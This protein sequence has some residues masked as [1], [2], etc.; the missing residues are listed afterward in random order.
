M[1]EQVTQDLNTA[2]AGRDREL[3]RLGQ[4]GLTP[5]DIIKLLPFIEKVTRLQDELDRASENLRSCVNEYPYLC[6]AHGPR[7]SDS[8]VEL[9]KEVLVTQ[10]HV[11]ALMDVE[12]RVGLI[13]DGYSGPVGLAV[14]AGGMDYML[15]RML[16]AEFG[17]SQAPAKIPEYDTQ[18]PVLPV[19]GPTPW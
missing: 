3:N 19:A 2:K 18:L 16:M 11:G 13:P 14:E 6:I 8:N 7:G 15:I 10:G 4:D 17:M 9:T 1:V 12:R 5:D